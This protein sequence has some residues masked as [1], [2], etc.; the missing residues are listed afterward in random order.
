MVY[1]KL[2]TDELPPFYY[3]FILSNPSKDSVDNLVLT[4][5]QMKGYGNRNYSSVKKTCISRYSIEGA[6]SLVS[7]P[8]I[9]YNSLHLHKNKVNPTSM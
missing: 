9:T 1:R 4:M 5:K 6:F 8:S 3:D 7:S 2:F